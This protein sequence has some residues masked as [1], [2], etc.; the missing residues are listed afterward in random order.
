V[1]QISIPKF[2]PPGEKWSPRSADT[3]AYRR[4]KPQSETERPE[5]TTE[6]Q[7]AR[8]RHK[9]ISNRNQGYL[10]SSESSSPT[11]ASLGYPNTQEK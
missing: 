7:M 6:N 2:F 10:A 5:N 1:L 3:Q 11:T 8:G 4:D 9:N